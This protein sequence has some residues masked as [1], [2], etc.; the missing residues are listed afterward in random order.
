MSSDEPIAPT[1]AW[2]RASKISVPS[3]LVF[4]RAT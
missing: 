1:E 3:S 2:R 4:D